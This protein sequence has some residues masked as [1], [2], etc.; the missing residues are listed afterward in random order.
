MGSDGELLALN[1]DVFGLSTQ[2]PKD[3]EIKMQW[4][5]GSIFPLRF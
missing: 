4:H 3:Q 1:A 2:P 5:A